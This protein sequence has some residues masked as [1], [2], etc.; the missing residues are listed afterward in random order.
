MYITSKTVTSASCP[1]VQDRNFPT[2][3]MTVR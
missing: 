1:C 3:G 2:M